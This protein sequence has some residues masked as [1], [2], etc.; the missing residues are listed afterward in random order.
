[1]PKGG[2]KTTFS[3]V[4][5]V[6]LF[7]HEMNHALKPIRKLEVLVSPVGTSRIAEARQAKPAAAAN[8]MKRLAD[9]GYVLY[10]KSRGVALTEEGASVALEV[11]FN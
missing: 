3:T 2:G 11:L 7:S 9:L 1:M 8:M 10:E 5:L 4:T 6:N